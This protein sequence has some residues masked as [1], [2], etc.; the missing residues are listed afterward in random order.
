MSGKQGDEQT[1]REHLP[2]CC[3]TPPATHLLS[4]VQEV[5]HVLQDLKVFEL[6]DISAFIT[7]SSDPD[8]PLIR[9]V[10]SRKC[11]MRCR[12]CESFSSGTLASPQQQQGPQWIT[13]LLSEVLVAP[14]A[15]LALLLLTLGIGAHPF[16]LVGEAPL[17]GGLLFGL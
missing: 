12:P 10:R 15:S 13:H 8:L 11:S 6:K 4:E 3:F 5:P 14:H 7:S 2:R 9:S 17:Q 1:R 16:Q